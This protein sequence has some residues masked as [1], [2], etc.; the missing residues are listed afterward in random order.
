MTTLDNSF[1]II[2]K[3]NKPFVSIDTNNVLNINIHYL[4]E[5]IIYN[6]EQINYIYKNNLIY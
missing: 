2:D 4:K 3:N 1:N 5:V 6:I